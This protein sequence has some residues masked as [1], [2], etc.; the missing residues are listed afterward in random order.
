MSILDPD[1]AYTFSQ[2]GKLNVTTDD[3]LS[4]YGYSFSRGLCHLPAHAGELG[5]LAETRRRIDEILPYVDL[6]NEA[7]RREVLIAPVV[8][9]IVYYT[10]A[11]LRIEYGIKVS[12]WLQGE[13]DYFLR[14]YAHLLVV[15]AK[16]E[17]ITKGFNQMAVEMISLDLWENAPSLEQQPLLVGA[18]TTG[19]IWRFGLLDRQTKHVTQSLSLYR[20]PEDLE[21][22]ERILI[23]ILDTPNAIN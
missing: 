7:A 8:T 16:Q 3:L 13:F 11:Q 1:R 14:T 20:V 12:N 18:V 21:S 6:S 4:E 15:E 17:D 19:E 22:V 2:V 9:D 10:H 5:R 23:G